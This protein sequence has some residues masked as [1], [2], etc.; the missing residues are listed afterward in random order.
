MQHLPGES[1]SLLCNIEIDANPRED[2]NDMAGRNGIYSS[3]ACIWLRRTG[4]SIPLGMHFKTIQVTFPDLASKLWH[5]AFVLCIERNNDGENRISRTR[6][7]RCAIENK[8]V[9]YAQDLE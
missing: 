8:V 6:E 7:N 1:I 2:S 9:A 3:V 5:E 4:N